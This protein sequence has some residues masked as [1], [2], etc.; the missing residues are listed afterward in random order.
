MA[1]DFKEWR[2]QYTLSTI[3]ADHETIVHA[4]FEAGYEA[5]SVGLSLSYLAE[6][7]FCPRCGKRLMSAL[8]PVSIHTC[9][10]PAPTGWDNGLSQDYDKKLGAWF[11]EKP[12][13]K[14]ELRARTF[15]DYGNKIA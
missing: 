6:R 14:E 13:A 9:C 12:N 10:P 8:G 15:D 2:D 7:H 11:S 3:Q 1:K 4:A 5:A